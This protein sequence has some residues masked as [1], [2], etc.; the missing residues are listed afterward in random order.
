[1]GQQCAVV[2]KKANCIL[3][4][5]QN[6]VSS[7]SREVILLLYS[8]LGKP[9]LQYCV[10]FWA[11]Q[12]KRDT[13]LLEQ[14]QKRATKMIRGLEHLSYEDRLRELVPFSQ[15]KRSLRGDLHRITESSRLE[16]TS[17]IT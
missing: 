4:S 8:I 1:M 3:G 6:S 15:E 7:R 11:P 9:Y 10:Q 12:Y 16:E 5:I 17:K 13:E 2:A 14:V